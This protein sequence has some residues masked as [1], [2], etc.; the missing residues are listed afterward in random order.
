MAVRMW[1]VTRVRGVCPA[2]CTAG[3]RVTDVNRYFCRVFGRRR[4][5]QLATFCHFTFFIHNDFHAVTK[6][7]LTQRR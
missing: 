4:K 3:R 2:F 5:K 7:L 1:R 6:L